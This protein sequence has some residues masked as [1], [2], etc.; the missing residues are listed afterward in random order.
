M[1]LVR[2]KLP[3]LIA[4]TWALAGCVDLPA[5]FTPVSLH[6]ANDL[7]GRP[8]VALVEA[9]DEGETG[10]LPDALLWQMTGPGAAEPSALPAGPVLVVG[11]SETAARRAAARLARSGNSAVYVFVPGNAEERGALVAAAMATK[12][13]LRGEDS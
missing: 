4:F 12:E 9:L 5:R 8:D 13:E 7:L 2:F 1:Q 11:S 3:A 10:R 6:E